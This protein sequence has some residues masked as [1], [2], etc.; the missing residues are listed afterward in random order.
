M[1]FDCFEATEETSEPIRS[2]AGMIFFFV[3]SKV[4]FVIEPLREVFLY[5]SNGDTRSAPHMCPRRHFRLKKIIEGLQKGE[6]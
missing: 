4:F 1:S 3:E 2:F 5:Q 6:N